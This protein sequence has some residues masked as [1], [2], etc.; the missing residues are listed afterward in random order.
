MTMQ[1][2][3]ASMMLNGC[4]SCC[5][6]P[7]W[8]AAGIAHLAMIQSS[9]GYS[10]STMCESGLRYLLVGSEV[11]L[12]RAS[13]DHLHINSICRQQLHI[14]IKFK[15]VVHDYHTCGIYNNHINEQTCLSYDC[16]KSRPR[17]R[18]GCHCTRF[19]TAM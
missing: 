1:P 5:H 14:Y 2:K 8:Y 10:D 18:Q 12:V 6:C 15:H 3:T 11:T 9:A 4:V 16:Q 19:R 17:Q 7:V 13:G